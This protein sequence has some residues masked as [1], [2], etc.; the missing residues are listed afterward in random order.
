MEDWAHQ[1]QTNEKKT[2]NQKVKMKERASFHSDCK[3]DRCC[4]EIEDLF[5][6]KMFQIPEFHSQQLMAIYVMGTFKDAFFPLKYHCNSDK[7]VQ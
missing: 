2:S 7:S 4:N 3:T 5:L 1:D 6:G